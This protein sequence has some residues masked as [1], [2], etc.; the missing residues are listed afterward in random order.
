MDKNESW[1][2][3]AKALDEKHKNYRTG[4]GPALAIMSLYVLLGVVGIAILVRVGRW[5]F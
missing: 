3:R 1:A 5:I 4:W 2:E